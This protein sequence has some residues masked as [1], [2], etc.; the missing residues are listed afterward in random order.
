M[1]PQSF[2]E[3]FNILM[4]VDDP[5]INK[6][7]TVSNHYVQKNIRFADFKT[8]KNN[9]CRNLSLL[10][11]LIDCWLWGLTSKQQYFSYILA[12]NKEW[13]IKWTWDDDEDDDYDD[14]D[15]DDEKKRR[16]T[17]IIE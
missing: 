4:E 9:I 11:R 15:D 2:T 7:Q 16:D 17:M 10:Y 1:G 3:S 8:Y 14:D 6:V 12:M 13:M 5:S